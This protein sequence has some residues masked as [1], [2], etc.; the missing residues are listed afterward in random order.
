MRTRKG[1]DKM[2]H[3]GRVMIRSENNLEGAEEIERE[4]RD[5]IRDAKMVGTNKRT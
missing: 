4:R 2:E 1:R 3:K 5:G